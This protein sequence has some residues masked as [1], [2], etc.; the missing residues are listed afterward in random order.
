M[1]WL[2]NRQQFD[3]LH[4]NQL[5]IIKLLNRILNQ[6]TAMALD[7]TAI[8]ANVANQTS[9]DAS[10]MTL[11]DNVA[12]ALAAIPASTDPTTQAAIDQLSTLISGNN[13]AIAADVKKNTP[14]AKP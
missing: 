8:T 6:E 14:A 11:L 10:I 4:A 3:T 7:L 12:A 13:D 2:V 9:V 1:S 5:T